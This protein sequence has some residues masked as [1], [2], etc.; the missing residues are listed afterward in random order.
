MRAVVF[1]PILLASTRRHGQPS[2]SRR[3]RAA[4]TQELKYKNAQRNPA[5]CISRSCVLAALAAERP[6][7]PTAA[8]EPTVAAHREI[9]TPSCVFVPPWLRVET[10]KNLQ[11]VFRIP[12]A[13]PFTVTTNASKRAG[14]GPSSRRRRSSSTCTRLIGSTYGIADVDRSTQH[15]VGLEQDVVPCH[16]EHRIDRAREAAAQVQPERPQFLSHQSIVLR[17]N[18]AIGLRQRHLYQVDR[19][20]EEGPLANTSLAVFRCRLASASSMP[21]HEGSINRVCVQ[22]NCH[23]IARRLSTPLPGVR[24]AGRL[25]MLTSVELGLGC[26]RAEIRNESRDLRTPPIDRSPARDSRL[27]PCSAPFGLRRRPR[28]HRRLERGGRVHLERADGDVDEPELGLNHLSLLGRA[29]RST[30]RAGRLR[31]NRQI[32]RAAAA[33]DAAAAPM[34]QRQSHVRTS[35][36][37]RRPPPVRGKAP[38]RRSAVPRPWPS[39]SSRSSLPDGLR[40]GRGTTESRAGRS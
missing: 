38:S 23:G 37:Q 6:T 4:R 20:R 24:R 33:A 26:G 18:A 5:S 14:S 7:K 31:L 27:R 34:E 22:A 16:G 29:Q 17:G 39:R 35:R 25:P 21:S 11:P 40:S 9:R 1:T 36:T 8:T 13:I 15:G 10:G 3:R 2:T 19:R 32:R 12:A 28:R 30:H